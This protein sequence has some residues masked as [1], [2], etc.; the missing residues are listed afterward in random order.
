M[1]PVPIYRPAPGQA[2]S[3]A[4][5]PRLRHPVVSWPDELGRLVRTAALRLLDQESAQEQE[6]SDEERDPQEMAQ[7]LAAAQLQ[8]QQA[9]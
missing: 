7:E 8:Q 4:K 5:R 2:K 9:G 3:P 1:P 6:S